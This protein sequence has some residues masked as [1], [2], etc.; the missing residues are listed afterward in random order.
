M[1]LREVTAFPAADD[2]PGRGSEWNRRAPSAPAPT[3]KTTTTRKTEMVIV[4][5]VANGVFLHAIGNGTSF[6][7]LLHHLL[8]LLL[9]ILLT[10]SIPRRSSIHRNRTRP[11]RPRPLT[12]TPT[13]T[14]P[15]RKLPDVPT[16]P[17]PS[18]RQ[19]TTTETTETTDSSRRRRRR[20]TSS[21]TA[22]PPTNPLPVSRGFPPWTVL[23]SHTWW[24][25]TISR[26]KRRRTTTLKM[27]RSTIIPATTK[28]KET[29]RTT[30]KKIPV[31]SIESPPRRP[32]RRLDFSPRRAW[33]RRPCPPTA[34]NTNGNAT[35]TTTTTKSA[36]ACDGTREGALS[37]KLRIPRGLRAKISRN[38]RRGERRAP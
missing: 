34:R 28:E 17:P 2:G 16:R 20:P 32:R 24:V 13:L 35:T 11:L 12:P 22:I 29:T 8:L 6:F 1:P 27:H 14:T 10:W 3:R 23:P 9:R 33:P 7:L 18:H 36:S 15:W 5:G 37:R 26:R 25:A 19:G 30:T 31:W 38:N 4:T 21:T